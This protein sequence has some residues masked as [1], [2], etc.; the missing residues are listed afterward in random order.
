[1]YDVD[2][3]IRTRDELGDLTVAFNDM[4]SSLRTNKEL[5]DE[6]RRENDR[7]LLAVMP[8]AAAQRYRD[9]AD[10]VV[11]EHPDVTVIVAE[12]DSLD[13]LSAALTSDESLS[14]VNTLVRQFDAAA[15]NLGVETV[16]SL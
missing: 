6:Q 14:V 8:E 2:L 9:G 5:I 11:I 1:D 15:E 12:T 7:L 4:G 16:Q 10:E 13:G 3:P